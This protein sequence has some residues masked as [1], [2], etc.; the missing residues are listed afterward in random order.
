MKDTLQIGLSK[1]MTI[2]VTEEMFAQFGGELVHPTYSTVAMVYHMEWVSRDLLLP[3]LEAHERGIG[4]EVS[5][6]HIAPTGLNSVVHVTATVKEI[7]SKKVVMEV[8]AENERGIIGKADFTQGVLP[9]HL[10][11]KK[12][13]NNGS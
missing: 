5:L 12:L 13:A 8:V 4:A 11:E 7:S 9:A 1:T 3:Y 6:K 2:T 10:L